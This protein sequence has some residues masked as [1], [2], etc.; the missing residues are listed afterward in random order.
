MLVRTEQRPRGRRSAKGAASCAAR[1]FATTQQA[2]G[3]HRQRAPV[4]GFE[5]TTKPL[6]YRGDSEELMLNATDLRLCWHQ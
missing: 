2:I 4:W 1:G 6:Y 3:R 5:F